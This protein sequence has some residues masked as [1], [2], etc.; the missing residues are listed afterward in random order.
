MKK[1]TYL[2]LSMAILS[3]IGTSCKTSEENYKAAYEIAARKQMGETG[4][5]VSGFIER[6]K[7][8]SDKKVIL[9][10]TVKVVTERVKMVDGED[11]A[12]Q[13]YSVVVGDFKQVFNA[14][15][16]CTRI[17]NAEN[18]AKLP[19]YVLINNEKRYYVVY[20]GFATKEEAA[21]F[22]SNKENFKVKSPLE[23]PWILEKL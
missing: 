14:R 18:N 11:A 10:D 15:S 20:R 22:L 2:M 7:R 1:V 16:F 12:I 19:A 6:E 13:N 9:G 17:N 4:R 3:L 5:D 8:L 21:T 23:E